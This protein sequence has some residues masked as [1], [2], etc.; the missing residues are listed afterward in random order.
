M[1]IYVKAL[2]QNDMN[3]SAN[4][5]KWVIKYALSTYSYT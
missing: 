4:T 3:Y 1:D 2:I 5:E